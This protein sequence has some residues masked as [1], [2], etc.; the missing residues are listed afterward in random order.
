MP[1]RGTVCCR[2]PSDLTYHHVLCSILDNNLRTVQL[3][4][5]TV[6]GTSGSEGAGTVPLLTAGDPVLVGDRAVGMVTSACHSATYDTG[7]SCCTSWALFT[8]PRSDRCEDRHTP[9]RPETHAWASLHVRV[10]SSSP[11]RAHTLYSPCYSPF[12]PHMQVLCLCTSTLT[13]PQTPAWRC[14]LEGNAKRERLHRSP[15]F[16]LLRHPSTH[17]LTRQPCIVGQVDCA[18]T[19][20]PRSSRQTHA[21]VVLLVL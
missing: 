12:L 20:A 9:C 11:P 18:A 16:C 5:C 7:T 6:D 17:H 1:C 19:P 4:H 8:Q 15:C 21:C 13:W 14:L 10:Q 3:L 2:E